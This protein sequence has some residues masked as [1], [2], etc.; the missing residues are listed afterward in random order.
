[1]PMTDSSA[2]ENAQRET[3]PEMT[4]PP[5]VPELLK[6]IV[7]WAVE[8]MRA[9]AGEIFL[10]D[11]ERAVL[12]QSISCG[13][14]EAYEGTTLRPGEGLGGRVFQS[15]EPMIIPDY[16][17]WEGKVA[18][19][20]TV[21][22]FVETFAVPMKWQDQTIGVL[23]IDADT[24][25]RAFDQ[26]DVRLATI[27]A[28]VATL[29]IKN[30]Q[31]YEELED[32][33]QKLQHTLERQVTQRT[34]ELAHRA[35]QLE[36]GALVS[37]EITAI[38]E[39]N[40]LL[41]RV[42]E[43][44]REAFEY[45]SVLVFLVDDETNRLV[46]RAASGA[47]GR[48]LTNQGLALP[49]DGKSLNST[50]V[51]TNEAVMVSDVSK[52]P[53]FKLVGWLPDTRSEVVI[54]LRVG[55]RVVGTLD[56][57]SDRLNAFQQDDVLVIQ[58]LGDQIAIAIENARLYDRSREL[59]I[60]EE[61][62]RL[63]RE[64]HDSVTQALFSVDLHARAIATYVKRDPE[65][66]E[67]QVQELRRTAHD[68]LQEMRSLILDLRPASLQD[69]GLLPALRQQ[70]AQLQQPDGPE[71]VF[72][73]TGNQRLPINVE[74]G[75][76]RIAQEALRNAI[77]HGQAYRITLTLSIGAGCVNLCVEDDGRGFDPEAPHANNRR[78]FGLIGIR[79]R[80]NLLNGS[81]E[82]AS[83]PGAGTQVRVRVPVG[84]EGRTP[85]N[86]SAS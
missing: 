16:G 72:H 4:S 9:D 73:A 83:Q 36:T 8:L 19:Y 18:P 58:S 48:R 56:V 82:I 47:A 37:R 15:G 70:I 32:R 23:A 51:Q 13:F 79:E 49:I 80:V 61:R 45:Y 27:F 12:V 1:M 55:K 86:P 52:E 62:T 11:P 35:L 71:L 50:T 42:V 24:R 6:S 43:L 64:L 21:A 29:A 78:A 20:E 14:I 68:A 84:V 26:D 2:A 67:V 17:A 44:I 10:W 66:A 46:L 38:L 57:Q 28:N 34:A 77:K 69:I 63:A 33:S 31:L 59:A 76:F 53:S 60:L 54:P 74:R 25:R 5:K 3:R 75:L 22:P 30:A 65:K 40:R 85:W 39:I 81:M 7:Q 41:T